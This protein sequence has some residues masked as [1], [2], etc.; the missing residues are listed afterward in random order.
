M[1]HASP[2]PPSE[3]KSL[4]GETFPPPSLKTEKETLR[5]SVIQDYRCKVVMGASHITLGLGPPTLL[6]GPWLRPMVDEERSECG[7]KDAEHINIV[8]EN[9]VELIKTVDTDVSDSVASGL[10]K[11]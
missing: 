11:T 5:V 7:G 8:S 3:T 6:R 10:N 2:P 1:H 9:N 4:M